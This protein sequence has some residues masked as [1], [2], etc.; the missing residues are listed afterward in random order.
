MHSRRLWMGLFVT[1]AVVAAAGY[2]GMRVHEARREKA[3]LQQA[4]ADMAAGRYGSARRRLL[5]DGRGNTASGEIAYLLGV[6]ELNQGRRGA[7]LAAWERVAP[8][9][10]WAA[11]AAVQQGLA[12]VDAGQLT[13]AEEVLTAARRNATGADALRVLHALEVLY[14]IEGRDDELRR[15]I[16]DSWPFTDSPTLLVQKLSW[17]DAAPLQ[18]GTLHKVLGT[19]ATDDDRVWLGRANLAIRTGN[20]EGAAR[21]LEGCLQ[22]RPL[23][24]VVWRARLELAEAAGDLAGAWQ[25]LEH[26]PADGLSLAQKART[27]AWLAARLG[28]AQRERVALIDLA[29]CDPGDIAALDK[30]ATFAALAGDK[31]E[32]ARIRSQRA[33][34]ATARARYQELLAG[35]VVESDNAERARVAEL[36]GRT[37]EAR[38]WA[39]LRDQKEGSAGPGRPALDPEHAASPASPAGPNR[40]ETLAALFADL[41]PEST[42][43]PAVTRPAAI[44]YIDAAETAGLRFIQDNGDSPQ[45]RLPETMSGGVALL[46]YDRDGWLDV[47]A[48]QGGPLPAADGQACGDR[49][50]RNRGDG[51]FDDVSDPAG[52]LKLKGGYGHGVA[53]GDYDGDGFP[54][55]FVTRWQA[56]ALL[57]NRGDGTFEDATVAAGLGGDRDWPTSAAWADLDGDGDLDLYVCHYLAYDLK[58]PR[59]CLDQRTHV[60]Q[61]CGPRAFEAR[62]DHVFRNDGG[63]FV[64]VT[65]ESGLTDPGGRGLGV[66]AADLD[67]DNR[68]DLYVANDLSANYLFRNL[69]GFRFEETALPAGAAANSSGGYQAGMGIACGDFDGDGRPDLAVTNYYG[70]STTFFRNLGHG[71]FADETSAIGLAA[72]TRWLLGFGIAFLDAGNDGWLDLVTAN[73]HV[74][75]QRPAH[76]WKMPTQLLVGGADGRVKAPA[77]AGAAFGPLHLGRG[78]AAGD[79]D[80]DGRVDVVVV[81]QNEP[82]VYLHNETEGENHWLT[83][84]LEGIRSNRDAVGACVS[85][86]SG[87]RWRVAQRTGGGSYQSAGDPRLHFGLGDMSTVEQVVVRWPSGTTDSYRAVPADQC[88]RVREAASQLEPMH[89][90]RSRSLK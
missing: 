87:G 67:G 1:A 68:I 43:R 48:V 2:A 52:I 72:P 66:V 45:K 90:R 82:L 63:R 47:Y 24:P 36:L 37:I 5:A 50:F 44:R 53:A 74:E 84:H 10:P 27:R 86:F 29:N 18:I 19:A 70:E 61:Y 76:A 28:D 21:L 69:G 88:Y 56:Y 34:I 75:D 20:L 26:L 23:D 33:K 49:I 83:L 79:L 54:D 31:K 64:D 15:S 78:L 7:A 6:C 60:Y 65:R 89:G 57:H 13:R 4:K 8:S 73:G 3:A 80:N 17:Q 77:G 55:L 32:A 22:R 35:K 25:A 16:I 42:H 11:A 46:D 12:L 81:A 9:S 51:T 62:P 14:E 38:G 40:G 59:L 41:R 30:L 58:N 39:L 85:V 71:L